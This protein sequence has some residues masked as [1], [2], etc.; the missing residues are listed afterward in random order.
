MKQ[1]LLEETQLLIKEEIKKVEGNHSKKS[2]KKEGIRQMYIWRAQW[3]KREKRNWQ[4]LLQE[5][6]KYY[7]PKKSE[8]NRDKY[9]Q[10]WWQCDI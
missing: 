8:Q 3:N 1:L 5:G 10:N 7:A 4:G 9:G 2:G 6:Q